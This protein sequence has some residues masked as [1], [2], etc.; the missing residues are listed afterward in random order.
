MSTK[1]IV[2]I[3][4]IILL[5]IA[6]CQTN[7]EPET[8]V[9]TLPATAETAEPTQTQEPQPAET[10]LPPTAT[11]QAGSAVL[12][13]TV[14]IKLFL[15]QPKVITVKTGT[16]VT[17]INHDDIQHTVTNGTPEETADAFDS[18]FF[19]LNES[20]T[21]TFLEP[22]TYQYF[23]QRHNHMQGVVEVLER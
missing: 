16:A 3:F 18:D 7:N 11:V 19:F 21:F 15:Y 20:Y 23:C 4:S 5:F 12:T 6:G 13:E 2:I 14:D 10:D 17:W 1:N 22:G 8:A 9:L